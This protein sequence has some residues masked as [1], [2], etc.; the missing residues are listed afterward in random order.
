MNP[1]LMKLVD[2]S[3]NPLEIF[4]AVML[5]YLVEFIFKVMEVVV[6]FAES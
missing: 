3:D 6:E 2:E 5:Y 4:F 1:E